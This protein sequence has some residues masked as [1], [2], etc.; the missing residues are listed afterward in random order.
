MKLFENFKNIFGFQYGK[1][2]NLPNSPNEKEL[3]PSADG[4]DVIT[5][6]YS[7]EAMGSWNHAGTIT[8]TEQTR[9][10]VKHLVMKYRKL[11]L[12]D[13]VDRAINNIIEDMIVI[14]EDKDP[15][16]LVLDNIEIPDNIKDKVVEEFSNILKIIDFKQKAYEYARTWYVDGKIYFHKVINENKK[17]EGIKKIKHIDSLLIFKEKKVTRK[18]DNASDASIIKNEEE[19]YTYN[20][21]FSSH[22]DIHIT[23]DSIAFAHSNIYMYQADPTRPYN[24][25]IISHLHKAIKPINNLKELENALVIYRIAR[26]PERRIF[27][28]DIAGM[29]KNKAEQY[30]MKFAAKYKNKF[31]YNTDTGEVTSEK[32]FHSAL[33]D[34]FIPRRNDGKTAEIT[35]L[36]GGQ[37]LGDIEDV[38]YFEKKVY[39]ALN[40]PL[41]RLNP[42]DMN[43]IGRSSEITRDEL[44][45][46]KFI[47]RLR[48]NFNDLWLD[49]L[50]TQ[51]V[52]K[53]IIKEYEWDQIFKNNIRFKYAQ[54][55]YIT[56][57]K[58]LEMMQEKLN[59]LRDLDDYTKV[60]SYYSKNYVR[61]ELLGQS[62]EDIESIEKDNIEYD[63]KYGTE[64]EEDL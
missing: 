57:L 12:V 53:G 32:G 24:R 37:S 34:Y 14:E 19:F 56:E 55:S 7:S 4:V 15:I 35:T 28:V 38:E 39:K 6:D 9:D 46:S 59:V 18:L 1:L 20:D 21:S 60:G 31:K 64:D 13:E 23:S 49:L 61:R 26:A 42:E 36:P 58:R 5:T 41:T 27:Y 8:S 2:D 11:S 40:V 52:L 62:D 44:K 33:E 30:M 50:K 47:Q 17:K 51:L 45:F 3:V 16:E 63:K 10:E 48:T 29:P 54:N 43:S 25:K 22:Q